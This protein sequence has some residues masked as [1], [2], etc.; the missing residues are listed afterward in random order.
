M[1]IK[2][3]QTKQAN[4]ML[5]EL[6]EPIPNPILSLVP[7]F[8]SLAIASVGIGIATNSLKKTRLI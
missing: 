8:Y 2:V 7:L 6:E 4:E 5:K 3:K 1:D